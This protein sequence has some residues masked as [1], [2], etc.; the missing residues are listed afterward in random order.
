MLKKKCPYCATVIT[1]NKLKKEGHDKALLKR[2][3]FPCPSCN[4]HISLP[5][6]AETA[7]SIG[8]LFA[9]VIAPLTYYWQASIS[10]SYL[11]FSIG[12][13]L[14]IFGSIKNQLQAVTKKGSNEKEG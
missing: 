6:Y 1:T 3:A 14:I 8:V 4:K 9:V 10:G 13:V 12:A 11:F 5:A 7:T 2:E